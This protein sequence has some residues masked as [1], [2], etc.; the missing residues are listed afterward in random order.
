MK[1]MQPKVSNT[2]SEKKS[3]KVEKSNKTVEKV[4]KVLLRFCQ[5]SLKSLTK[6]K[7]PRFLKT[8][9]CD[10]T[11]TPLQSCKRNFDKKF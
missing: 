2:E 11:Q 9:E 10:R 4:W 1:E 5:K 7:Y 6:P 3:K 8:R